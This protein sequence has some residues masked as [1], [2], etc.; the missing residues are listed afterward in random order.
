MKDAYII[1]M[2]LSFF[3]V[4]WLV[5]MGLGV[6]RQVKKLNKADNKALITIAIDHSLSKSVFFSLPI[7]VVVLFLHWRLVD[8][9][10]V[11]NMWGAGAVGMVVVMFVV[12][13][14]L[15]WIMVLL[16]FVLHSNLV[17]FSS[18][19]KPLPI[20]PVMQNMQNWP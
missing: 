11:K 9:L 6:T 12:S 20:P 5:L 19:D 13:M 8:L 3:L 17:D 18:E 1:D 2:F 7:F 14:L 10:H 16:T 4:F 15:V